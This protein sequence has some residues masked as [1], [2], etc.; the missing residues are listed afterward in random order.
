MYST[1]YNNNILFGN[2]QQIK[3]EKNVFINKS[4]SHGQNNKL[5]NKQLS[6]DPKIN[7]NFNDKNHNDKNYAASFASLKVT[8]EN[9]NK[10]NNGNNRKI[11]YNKKKIDKFA[12]K[13]KLFEY[14][15]QIF[16]RKKLHMKLIN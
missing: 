9:G 8:P 7:F 10:G 13:Q 14:N 16:L 4:L 3:K 5:N 2:S 15:K 12:Q 11:Y 6:P 1:H